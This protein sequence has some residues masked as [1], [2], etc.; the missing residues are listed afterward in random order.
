MRKK[1]HF[2][3]LLMTLLIAMI[4]WPIQA[5]PQYRVTILV[6]ES[7]P[8]YTYVNNGELAGVYVDLVRQAI[9]LIDDKYIVELHPVPWK[10]G[11]AALENGDSFALM[12]PYKHIKRRP[13]IWPYSVPLLEEVVVAFCNKGVSLV[14]IETRDTTASPINVGLNA[15]YMILDDG[16]E[17]A[18][19]Q[20]KIKLWENKDTYSN[21]I[22]LAKRR[23]DCYVN[24]RLSTLLGL[25]NVKRL[26]PG[27]DL[28]N[29]SE[30]RVVVRHTAHIGYVKDSLSKFPYKHDFIKKMDEALQT[31]L[32]SQAMELSNE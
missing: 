9:K 5:E 3:S 25:R 24:D 8:P 1:A 28:N 4:I 19:K 11:L 22:K 2:W 26:H 16:L 21:I 27:F 31:V 17:Q 18:S 15:G 14:D 12:P 10:R 23:I 32:A 20:G 29:L 30:D 6:D 7:Y 13:F